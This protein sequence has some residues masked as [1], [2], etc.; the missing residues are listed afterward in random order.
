MTAAALEI[1]TQNQNTLESML[2]RLEA[3]ISTYPEDL[4]LIY[5]QSAADLSWAKGQFGEEAS[6][7]EGMSK[8]DLAMSHCLMFTLAFA[9]SASSLPG[10]ELI[11]VP[12]TSTEILE[13]VTNAGLPAREF[14][15]QYGKYGNQFTWKLLNL[16]GRISESSDQIAPDLVKGV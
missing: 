6:D 3:T 10:R 9:V 16:T 7:F 14:L 13:V 4:R 12:V 5:E 2:A 1:S 11:E 8:R 15:S